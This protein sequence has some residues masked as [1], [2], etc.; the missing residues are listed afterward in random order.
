MKNP[1]NYK[2][3]YERWNQLCNDIILNIRVKL[4]ETE[5][6]SVDLGKCVSQCTIHEFGL[7]QE[8]IAMGVVMEKNNRNR[9]MV[10]YGQYE[11]EQSM[12]VEHLDTHQLLRL[13]NVFE[14]AIYDW[15]APPFET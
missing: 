10:Y 12:N 15:D 9:V 13:F 6:K 11:P 14:E 7:G 3:Y 4:E 1:Q 5:T 8:Q 2:K